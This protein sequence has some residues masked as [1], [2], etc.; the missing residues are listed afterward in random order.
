MQHININIEKNECFCEMWWETS[1]KYNNMIELG[2]P[3]IKY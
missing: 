2:N 1:F 3:I